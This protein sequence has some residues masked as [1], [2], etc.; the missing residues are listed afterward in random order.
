[1]HD[2]TKV[3]KP[4]SVQSASHSNEAESELAAETPAQTLQR[5][6]STVGKLLQRNEKVAWIL[7]VIVLLVAISPL[8]LFWNLKMAKDWA[9]IVKDVGESVGI[10]VAAFAAI[11]WANERG[12]RA[13]TVLM[14]LETRFQKADV[15]R[16]KLILEF[17]NSEKPVELKARRLYYH[18]LDAVLRFYVILADVNRSRQVPEKSLSYCFGFWLAHYFHKDAAKLRVYIDDLYP[19]T[20]KWLWTDLRSGGGF[21]NAKSYLKENYDS[22]LAVE[23]LD[24]EGSYSS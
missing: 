23:I 2:K 10:L 18:D 4:P 5:F 20:K 1:M 17:P 6:E 12:D 9:G 13:T 8:F 7:F 11:K 3:S 14:E 24:S 21:F 15:T 22:A 16:G 19:G